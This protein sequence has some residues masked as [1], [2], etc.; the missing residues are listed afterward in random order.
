MNVIFHGWLYDISFALFFQLKIF[1]IF[2]FMCIVS[3]FLVQQFK[4]Y[5]KKRSPEKIAVTTKQLTT[6]QM[7][8]I[9]SNIF[10]HSQ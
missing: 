1:I 8:P 2:I 3:H 4:I 6:E 7:G 5:L 10:V 9:N